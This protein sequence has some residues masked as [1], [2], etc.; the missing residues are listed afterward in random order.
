MEKEDA[1]ALLQSIQQL[2]THWSGVI[3]TYM[4]YATIMNVAI[5]GYFLK[6][7]LDSLSQASSGQP[8]Y[9]GV[10]AAASVRI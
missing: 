5:W 8:L 10:A 7:Y 1:R 9:I 6:A 4:G 2:R 3:T